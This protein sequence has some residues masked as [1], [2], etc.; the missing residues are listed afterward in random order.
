MIG[1]F[2]SNS[3]RRER[4]DPLPATPSGTRLYAVGDIHGRDDLLVCLQRMI[5]NDAAQ[6]Q[7]ERNIVI[8]LGDYVDRGEGSR[9]VIDLLLKEPIPGFESVHLKGN[10]EDIMLRFLD[11]VTVAPSWLNFGGMET[12][13]SY[14]VVPPTPH[15][16]PGEH[17]AAQRALNE[18]LPA[19]HRKFLGGLRSWHEEG[20]YLFVHA[21]L[22]PGIAPEEQRDEDLFWIR[23]DFLLSDASFGRI[24]VH[25]HTIAP[26]PVVRRNRI[27]IDTG[28]YASGRLTALVA[29]GTEWSFL[30]T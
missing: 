23:E 29:D 18:R 7:A 25:G 15:A 3:L 20:D 8:Y 9:A 26:Q 5:F 16:H 11:D 22:R 28:A 24:V 14:G 12:L 4:A 2:F 6:H 30:Q 13:A 10:H 17:L 1:R 27:G 21:G 19:D